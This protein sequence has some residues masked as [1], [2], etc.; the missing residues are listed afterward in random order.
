MVSASIL[1]G[2]RSILLCYVLALALY[3]T[4][5]LSGA[6]LFGIAAFGLFLLAVGLGVF[7]LL[8]RTPWKPGIKVETQERKTAASMA[9]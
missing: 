6:D 2:K 3:V 8:V 7:K 9:D 5:F 4:R 1:L